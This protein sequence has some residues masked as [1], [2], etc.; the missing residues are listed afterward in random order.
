MSDNWTES[1]SES[2]TTAGTLEKKLKEKG[3]DLS[4][5]EEEQIREV[6]KKYPMRIN[7]YYF[8]LI[9]KKGDEIWNQCVPRIEEITDE[10]GEEDPLH[11]ENGIPCLTHRYPD[12]VLITVS[13]QCGMYCRFCTRKRKV[14]CE[15][16][17]PSKDNIEKTIDYVKGHKEVRDV[18]LSGGDPL[19][20]SDERLEWILKEFRDIKHLDMIRIGTR[21]P[22]VL[23]QR[24]TP[25]LCSILKAYNKNPPLYINTH[26]EHPSEFTEESKL[27]CDMLSDSGIPLGNQSI[28]LKDVNSNPE[29]MKELMQ[30][31]LRMKVRPYYIYQPDLVRGTYHFIESVSKGLKIIEGLRG[32]TSGLAVPH[33]VID[34][35]GGEGKVPITPEYCSLNEDGSVNITSYNGQSSFYPNP[36]EEKFAKK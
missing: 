15:N 1:L 7:S 32:Y 9:K 28:I 27:A 33:Y 11:E 13:N 36:E 23:P 10:R 35:P 5:R 25:E 31:L 20:L 4:E 18:I 16:R 22:C 8:S 2:I 12:R 3:I 29:T 17:N 14:G 24:I 34:S 26:F 6:A 19:L 30:G 21:I